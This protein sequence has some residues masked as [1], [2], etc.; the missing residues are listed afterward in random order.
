MSSLVNTPSPG[1]RKK[2]FT[3]H[4]YS[5]ES[6]QAGALRTRETLI[7]SELK[8]RSKARRTLTESSPFIIANSEE[9]RFFC[10]LLKFI[11][12]KCV[13]SVVK[14]ILDYPPAYQ[15]VENHILL[16]M[17]SNLQVLCGKG[18]EG[19]ILMMKTDD[20]LVSSVSEMAI[21]ELKTRVPFLYKTLVSAAGICYDKKEW[22]LF[23]IYSMLMR[24]R[25]PNLNILQR[26][27]TSSCM[28]Y[29][30]GNKVC[31]YNSLNK[32]TIYSLGLFFLFFGITN[33]IL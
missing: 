30:A 19:S 31:I 8:P 27:V 11:E 4:A 28:R 25:H 24:C 3:D 21:N 18:E 10:N 12:E 14:C 15:I 1:E 20:P 26:L 29:H 23:A 6:V 16:H 13:K 5:R 2:S 22:H 32:F 9:E 7:R 33:F 17:D